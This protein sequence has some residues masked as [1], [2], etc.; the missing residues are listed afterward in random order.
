MGHINMD[1]MTQPWNPTDI[2]AILRLPSRFIVIRAG[3]KHLRQHAVS[4]RLTESKFLRHG[5]HWSCD[6]LQSKQLQYIFAHGMNSGHT[7]CHMQVC[8]HSKIFTIFFTNFHGLS[9]HVFHG[10]FTVIGPPFTLKSRFF[11]LANVHPI[12]T[13]QWISCGQ[14]NLDCSIWF[15]DFCTATYSWMC[16]KSNCCRISAWAG[17]LPGHS[18]RWSCYMLHGGPQITKFPTHRPR[19]ST[20]LHPAK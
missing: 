6:Q 15:S 13:P 20:Y 19:G 9:V 10:P 7:G 12:C 2:D 4:L 11:T 3:S 1:R 16:F 8:A 17:H 18:I 14:A 5:T